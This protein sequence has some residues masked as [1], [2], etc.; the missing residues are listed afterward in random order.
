M[1]LG[2]LCS[3]KSRQTESNSSRRASS[4]SRPPPHNARMRAAVSAICLLQQRRAE[5]AELGLDDLRE[6]QRCQ[7][8]EH[9]SK[10]LSPDQ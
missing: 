6:A 4:R 2:C 9:R 7:I 3:I 8:L 1:R 5:A 10:H